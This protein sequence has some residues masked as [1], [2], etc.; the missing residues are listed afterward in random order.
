MIDKDLKHGPFLYRVMNI[1]YN[2]EN[3]GGALYVG[4]LWQNC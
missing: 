1:S 4:H 2:E 3:K